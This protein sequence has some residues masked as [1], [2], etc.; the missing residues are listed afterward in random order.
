MTCDR[1]I[2]KVDKAGLRESGR[3]L[4]GAAVWCLRSAAVRG[5]SYLLRSGSEI[6]DDHRA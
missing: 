5:T 6:A 4:A 2:A 3:P 1:Q